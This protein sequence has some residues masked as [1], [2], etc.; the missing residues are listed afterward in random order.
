[1]SCAKCHQAPP[2]ESDTWCLGCISWE[3]LGQELCSTWRLPGFRALA[4]DQCVSAVR[5]VRGLRVLGNSVESARAS[6][7]GGHR[8]REPTDRDLRRPA[9][10]ERSPRR[11]RPA[12]TPP[13]GHQGVATSTSAR[14]KPELDEEY[15]YTSEEDLEEEDEEEA[16]APAAAPKSAA[17][18]KAKDA[19]D[20]SPLKRKAPQERKKR[21][22]G[23]PKRKKIR[24]G[25]RKHKRLHRTLRDPHK[26]VHRGLGAG[27]WDSNRREEDAKRSR[28]KSQ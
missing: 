22:K 1:M 14:V 4:A 21:G 3:K 12:A 27:F 2:V 24:R 13:S 23:D 18:D 15:T 9:H 11:G 16:P 8:E 7:A 5:A 17:S 19:K 6:S 20:R 26:P 25:G 10:P 28:S